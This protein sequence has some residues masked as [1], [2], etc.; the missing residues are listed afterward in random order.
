MTFVDVKG[1]VVELRVRN[2]TKNEDEDGTA[3]VRAGKTNY[4]IFPGETGAGR[5]VAPGGQVPVARH[6]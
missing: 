1:K 4:F 6:A 2:A 5:H 3:N